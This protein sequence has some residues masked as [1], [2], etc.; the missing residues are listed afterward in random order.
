MDC[1]EC[2]KLVD[3]LINQSVFEGKLLVQLDCFFFRTIPLLPLN[4]HPELFNLL[5]VDAFRQQITA[6]EIN[7]QYFFNS[8]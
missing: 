2:G 5:C 4:E 1:Y 6:Q 8:L 7:W 3:G